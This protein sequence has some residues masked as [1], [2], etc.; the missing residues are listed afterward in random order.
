MRHGEAV[1]TKGMVHKDAKGQY[2]ISLYKWLDG[3]DSNVPMIC[4]AQCVYAYLTTDFQTRALQN[5]ILL[6]SLIVGA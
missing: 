6:E 2:S 5:T 1:G 4:P 3:W